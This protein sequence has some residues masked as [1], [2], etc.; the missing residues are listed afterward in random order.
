[1]VRSV[2]RGGTAAAL[3]MLALAGAACGSGGRTSASGPPPKARATTTTATPTTTVPP[4][5]AYLTAWGATLAAWNANHTLDPGSPNSY[6]PRLGD[7]RDTY[8]HLD[9]VDG[10]VVGYVL[11][12]YP[13]MT[14]AGAKA[15]IANDLPLDAAV[16]QDRTLA[17]CELFVESSPTMAVAATG[18]A[19][20]ELTSLS[21]TYD[22]AAVSTVTVFP[23]AA[24]QPA[25]SSCLPS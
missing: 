13:A 15:R 11:A 12:L 18:G 23:R 19:L 14:S 22:P 24:G 9:V 2:R 8:T 10:R 7:N 17:G 20:V 6:W 16:S 1:M 4:G 5:V 3:V 25:P 21:P